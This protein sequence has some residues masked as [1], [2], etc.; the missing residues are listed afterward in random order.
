MGK[1]SKYRRAVKRLITLT[2]AASL[3]IGSVGCQK[4]GNQEEKNPSGGTEFASG[5]VWGAPSTVRIRA[6]HIDYEDKRDA[7]LNFH[8]VRNEYESY[9]LF[10]TASKEITSY[11]LETADLSNGDI[12][13]SKDNFEVYYE[14]CIPIT[15]TQL[16]SGDYPDA[17]I[18]ID[19]AKEYDELKAEKDTNTGLW[20][21]VHVPK[22]TEA[23]T[24]SG[25]FKLTADEGT[26]DIP[27]TLEVN[28]YTLTDNVNAATLFSW[29][30]DRVAAGELD[31]SIEMMTKYYEFFLDY[32]I[33][34]QSLPME[35]LNGEEMIACLEKYWDRIST[36]CLLS[37]VGEISGNLLGDEDRF[38]EQIYALAAASTQERDYFSKCYAYFLDEPVLGNASVLKDFIT[39]C[40]QF[41]T[42]LQE[43]V[44]VIAADNTGKYDAFKSI[45]NWQA[46]VLG[47]TNIIPTNFQAFN[48]LFEDKNME[49]E[50]GK[51][52]SELYKCFCPGWNYFADSSRQDILDFCEKYNNKLWW[53][54]CMGPFEPLPS[55]LIGIENLLSLRSVS[56]LQKKY[57]IGGNLYWDAAAYTS[58]D[59]DSYNQYIDVYTNP[60]RVSHTPCGDGFLCYPGKPYGIDGPVTSMR[61]MSLRDGMEEYEMLLELENI[62]EEKKGEFGESF[63][64]DQAMD[65]FYSALYYDGIHMNAD[66]ESGLD[67]NELRA[68]MMDTVICAKTGNVFAVTECYAE[69]NDVVLHYYASQGTQI[70]LDGELQTPVSDC[71]YEIKIPSSQKSIAVK[72]TGSDGQEY[73]FVRSVP[74]YAVDLQPISDASAEGIFT[75]SEGSSVRFVNTKEYSTDGTAIYAEIKG[76]ITGDLLKDGAF[77]PTLSLDVS[78]FAN[79]DKF[80]DLATLSMDIYN[81]G[82]AFL[83]K[84]RVYSGSSYTDL[85]EYKINKGENKLMIAVSGISFA[86]IDT[87][88]RI[89]FIFENSTDGK[90]ANNYSFYIDNIAG[91]K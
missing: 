16:E 83:T 17:L 28:D 48:W 72:M 82:E 34:L 14:K 85:D 4:K 37:E 42:W 67:F 31:G 50:T 32:R 91:T 40:T 84:L 43:C 55:Y 8:A 23:G 88:D 47:V 63:S 10:I 61:L 59:A 9:Q 87:V 68:E 13:F 53:Y 58:E 76:R 30:Y 19:A 52:V 78:T 25:K 26:M 90:T 15:D 80:S 79:M 86:D 3:F 27:V 33:S 69:G 41:E 5:T 39:K 71:E 2:L 6:D 46:S 24:Y 62:Y 45:E 64:V 7:A 36:F 35:S 49:T 44:D 21:T 65:S 20:V 81:P 22:D 54:G 73:E 51:Q 75:A 29:R 66:G 11:Y 18:P 57:D 70:Y 74:R 56:W 38:K 1:S 12:S 60:Y 89:E 77:V